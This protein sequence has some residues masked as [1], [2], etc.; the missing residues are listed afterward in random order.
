L[1]G[2]AALRRVIAEDAQHVELVGAGRF[3]QVDSLEHVDAA[4][5][6]ARASA[7]ERHCG[8]ELVAEV[9]QAAAVAGLRLDSAAAGRLENDEGHLRPTVHAP[10]KRFSAF[11]GRSHALREARGETRAR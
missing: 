7:R 8:A 6:A 1:A 3:E 5:S 11:R 10:E 2:E 9:D 4:S